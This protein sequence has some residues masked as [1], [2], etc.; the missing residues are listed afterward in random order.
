MELTAH[1][2]M[3]R[4]PRLLK[5]KRI[6][7][8]D[9]DCEFSALFADLMEDDLDVVVDCVPDYFQAL[10]RLKHE[11]YDAMLVDW[12]AKPGHSGRSEVYF[13][14]VGSMQ[15]YLPTL[16][17]SNLKNDD[18]RFIEDNTVH[19]IGLISKRQSL[20]RI[21][22]DLRLRLDQVFDFDLSA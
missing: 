1:T 6:L 17:M 2:T 10:D 12:R 5:K 7:M 13:P 15:E 19:W 14:I 20:Q 8:V 18:L 11:E 4:M 16:L 21:L 22:D 9:D 3:T